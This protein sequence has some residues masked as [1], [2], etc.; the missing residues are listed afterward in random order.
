MI[1]LIYLGYVS[2]GMIIMKKDVIMM[3]LKLKINDGEFVMLLIDLNL[4]LYLEV[5]LLGIMLL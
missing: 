5:G 3:F 4:C 2:H 1:Q